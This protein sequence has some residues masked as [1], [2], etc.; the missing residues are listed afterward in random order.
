ME[1]I[2]KYDKS[3]IATRTRMTCLASIPDP[4]VKE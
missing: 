1:D 2:L 4:K 3:D